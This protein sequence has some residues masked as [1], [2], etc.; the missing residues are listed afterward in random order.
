M[1]HARRL[2]GF[3]R[4][5]AW[6]VLMSLVNAGLM[7]GAA[8]VLSAIGVPD[9]RI[10]GAGGGFVFLLGVA[11]AAGIAYGWISWLRRAKRRAAVSIAVLPGLVLAA[12][13]AASVLRMLTG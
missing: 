8:P 7:L 9:A 12:W 5:I 2:M 10:H 1:A 4:T 11:A 3:D 13:A 6:L